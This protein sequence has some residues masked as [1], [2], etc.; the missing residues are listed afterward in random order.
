MSQ[1]RMQLVVSN[2]PGNAQPALPAKFTMLSAGL[3]ELPPALK[4]KLERLHYLRPA[5]LVV[6]EK[7]ADN[8]LSD[9]EL[10]L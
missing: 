1:R 8:L 3:R 5:V 7:L 6:I 2:R 9:S 10:L 4:K